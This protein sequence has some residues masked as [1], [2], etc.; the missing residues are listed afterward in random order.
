MP[1]WDA[2][3]YASHRPVYPDELFNTVLEFLGDA[4]ALAVDVGCGSGQVTCAL[5]ARFDRVVGIDESDS[6]LA[7]AP[8][9]PNI[10]YR[11]GSAEAT[12]LPAGCS[13]LVTVAAAL[14]WFDLRGFY[15]EARRL[16]RPG[17][18]LAAWSYNE[19]PD[20]A[21]NTRALEVYLAV[22]EHFLAWFDPRLLKIMKQ[23]VQTR[24]L[25]P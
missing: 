21:G 22:R 5:A 10:E 15:A 9:R 16:L 7:S 8:S 4:R 11:C 23:C 2:K 18:A 25:L 20:F 3:A 6:Q 17:G 14:H 19:L 24:C 1:V 12:G 13:D